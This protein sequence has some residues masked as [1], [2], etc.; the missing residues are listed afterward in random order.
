MS[1]KDCL[2][3]KLKSRNEA[4]SDRITKL[5]A[6]LAYE[7]KVQRQNPTLEH[8]LRLEIDKLKRDNDCLSSTLSQERR[9]N[10]NLRHEIGKL[11]IDLVI[12]RMANV[13][14]RKKL[15][16]AEPAS[17]LPDKKVDAI[18]HIFMD[19]AEKPSEDATV[20]IITR[21]GETKAGEKITKFTGEDICIK[22][23]GGLAETM[24]ETILQEVERLE[25][26]LMTQHP[27]TFKARRL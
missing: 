16:A 15:K 27:L 18:H 22:I 19:L 21:A 4:L 25:K 9:K 14:L 23:E 2:I 8:E 6:R 7:S 10:S 3:E 20:R 11:K 26:L 1:C 17:I 24:Q 12:S 13:G 5:D